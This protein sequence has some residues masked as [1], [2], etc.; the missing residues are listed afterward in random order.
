MPDSPDLESLFFRLYLDRHI[1]ARF[2]AGLRGRGFDVLRTKAALMPV[3]R[4][5]EFIKRAVGMAGVI[6]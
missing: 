5:V 1:M 3:P 4:K 2:A 6:P